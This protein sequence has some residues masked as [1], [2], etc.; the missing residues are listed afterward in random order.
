MYPDV[1]CLVAQL[2]SEKPSTLIARHSIPTANATSGRVWVEQ[3]SSAPTRDWYDVSTSGGF[4]GRRARFAES[5]RDAVWQ[6]DAR[7]IDGDVDVEEVR[8][9]SFVLD[10]PPKCER[11]HEVIV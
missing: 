8:Y 10:V 2:E 11:L 1:E 9:G 7:F 3:Y 4:R 6:N 5:E